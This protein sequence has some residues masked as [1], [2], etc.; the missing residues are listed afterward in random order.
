MLPNR[1][2]SWVPATPDKIKEV[3]TYKT[4]LKEWRTGQAITKQQIAGTIPD[5]LFIQIKNL[6]T[7]NKIFMHLSNLFEQRS[8]VV[9]VELLRKLQ[10]LKCPEKGNVHEHFD[11]MH[12]AKEQLSSLGHAPT[13]ES[14]ATMIMSSLSSSY[15]PHLSALTASAKVSSVILTADTLMSTIIDEY[16]RR[17]LKSKKAGSS[18][19]DA[20]YNANASQ[21][22]QRIKGNCHNC[23][24]YGHMQK[25]CR[26]PGG[27]GASGKG[28]PDWKGKDKKP[29][30][31]ASAKD[32]ANDDEPEGVWLMNKISPEDER[33]SFTFATL[34]DPSGKQDARIK[35]L[36]SGASRHM[37]SHKDLFQDFVSITPKPITMV[38]KHTFEAISKGS[39]L[40][41]L[42]NRQLSTKILL[43]D[44]LYAPKM[45]VTL[46]SISR[47]TAAGYA[48]LFRE[49]LCKIFDEKRRKLG[50]IPVNKGLY[51]IKRPQKSFAGVAKANDV[52]T[53]REIH[54][55]LGHISPDSIRQMIKDGV[56]T[57]ITLDPSDTTME[58]CDSYEY[59]K[60][61]HKP[62][63]K[64]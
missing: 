37:S 30:T 56:I 16:D 19:D 58:K 28:K 3:S 2:T 12:T 64:V 47:L 23:G 29:E 51:C 55:R 7:A 48:A 32:K 59:A 41:T 20:A 46:I 21:R 18:N 63:G 52:L 25:D 62:I 27:G 34:T 42:P 4:E 1:G 50:E 60:V 13:D 49:T 40:I 43:K 11:K 22:T 9:S 24:K 36:D 5:S 10:D 15:D 8:C 17:S 57:G 61:T 26:G 31:A 6:N 33:T 45:G 53:M 39:L 35:L 38:D 54:A 44:V 14:F